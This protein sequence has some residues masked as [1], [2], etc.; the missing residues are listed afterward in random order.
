MFTHALDATAAAGNRINAGCPLTLSSV[1]RR[2]DPGSWEDHSKGQLKGSGFRPGIGFHLGPDSRSPSP[3]SRQYIASIRS[4]ASWRVAD[5]IGLPFFSV[6]ELHESTPGQH[7]HLS[8]PAADR[9]GNAP[10]GVWLGA[11]DVGQTGS[12]ERQYHRHRRDDSGTQRSASLHLHRETGDRYNE[13]LKKL[14]AESGIETPTREQLPKFD[15]KRSRKRLEPRLDEIGRSGF[16]D[17]EDEDGRTHLA[18][19]A[20]HAV[21]LDTGAAV[22]VVLHP[23]TAGDTQTVLDT[24]PYA[25]Q[26]RTFA[27]PR[28]RRLPISALSALA[29]S[30]STRGYKS[31]RVLRTLND[32]NMRSYCSE[33]DRGRRRW[34][35]KEAEKAAVY[36][37]TAG[38]HQGI[39]RQTTAAAAP[40]KGGA[41]FRSHVRN[42]SDERTICGDTRT[43]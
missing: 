25:K 14:A 33:P 24:L 27:P 39:S 18:H 38:P 8:D 7:G 9:S 40:R 3:E 42:R 31:N 5:R 6:S 22:A 29:N 15:R 16:A 37:C 10:D 11:E 1:H 17:W 43:F 12:A 20:E 36:R 21:D 35:D 2:S 23:A 26:A 28:I 41:E 34:S 30:F 4:W 19:K 13:F 32:W